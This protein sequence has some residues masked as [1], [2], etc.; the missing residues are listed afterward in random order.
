MTPT[1]VPAPRKEPA[2]LST[3]KRTHSDMAEDTI[4]VKTAK[5]VESQKASNKLQKKPKKDVTPPVSAAPVAAKATTT[6]KFLKSKLGTMRSTV[7]LKMKASTDALKKVK[8]SVVDPKRRSARISEAHSAL[9]ED[10]IKKDSDALIEQSNPNCNICVVNLRPVTGGDCA[11]I[12][13]PKAIQAMSPAEVEKTILSGCS[14]HSIAVTGLFSNETATKTI[15]FAFVSDAKAAIGRTI[16]FSKQSLKITST[17][18][19]G[20]FFQKLFY[21]VARTGVLSA[22]ELAV[23]ITAGFPKETH[24][25]LFQR[26]TGGGSVFT[27][28]FTIAFWHS[29]LTEKTLALPVSDGRVL[30]LNLRAAKVSDC[31]ECP[32]DEKDAK[33]APVCGCYRIVEERPFKHSLELEHFE[34]NSDVDM[35]DSFDG[36]NGMDPEISGMLSDSEEN[37]FEETMEA[38]SA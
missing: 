28:D 33:D 22:S 12:T 17:P 11:F 16:K 30:E 7:N 3:K 31:K 27:S 4:S 38:T 36:K 26:T 24:F 5:T 13:L 8:D 32:K 14:K 20:T 34:T 18:P 29:K 35:H 2:Y 23:A 25:Q 15:R 1:P 10:E 21:T 37:V 19:I 6:N 9:G